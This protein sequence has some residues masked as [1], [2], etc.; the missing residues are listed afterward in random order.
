MEFDPAATAVVVVDMQ[1]GFCHSGG[2]LY[3][4]PSEEVGSALLAAPEAAARERGARHFHARTAR[5]QEAAVAF[6]PANG[7]EQ[8]DTDTHGE[9]GLVVYR[10][11]LASDRL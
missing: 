9:D 10:K 5:R 2:S 1:N 3:A 11:G 7:Y 8:V 4:P 6:Y